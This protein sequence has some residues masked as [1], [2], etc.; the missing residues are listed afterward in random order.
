MLNT[1]SSQIVSMEVEFIQGVSEMKKGIDTYPRNSGHL[2][3]RRTQ[4]PQLQGGSSTITDNMS[5]NSFLTKIIDHQY[6]IISKNMI[7]PAYQSTLTSS[8]PLCLPT[9][10]EPH[11]LSFYPLFTQPVGQLV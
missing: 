11:P 6:E 5:N 1:Y 9:T 3:R 4:Q 7:L 10:M 8:A 2:V